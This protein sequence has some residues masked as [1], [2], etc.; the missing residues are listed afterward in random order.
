MKFELGHSFGDARE[1][2]LYFS[3]GKG[4]DMRRLFILSVFALL[5]APTAAVQC[6][7]KVEVGDTVSQVVNRCGEPVRRERKVAQS[8]GVQVIRGLDSLHSKPLNPQV[9]EKWYYDTN[10]NEATVIEILDGGVISVRRL[11]REKHPPMEMD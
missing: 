10:L 11:V 5:S 9:M 3:H 6:Y 1:A 4:G 7:G 2:G 8:E